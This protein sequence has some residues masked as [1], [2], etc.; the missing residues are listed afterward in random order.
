MKSQTSD[1]M[2]EGR[3]A[4]RNLH[5]QIQSGEVQ[6]QRNDA[7]EIIETIQIFGH[8][9]GA[10]YAAGMAEELQRLNYK[11]ENVYYL[12]PHQPGGIIHPKGIRGQQYSHPKDQV[13]S[14]APSWLP[15]GKSSL[16]PIQGIG[17]G[18]REYQ[19]PSWT[20]GLIGKGDAG[21]HWVS[22]HGYIFNN[23]CEG[24]PGYVAPSSS[25]G[26]AVENPNQGE[27]IKLS[28]ESTW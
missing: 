7:G 16:A 26:S 20:K 23:T 3:I 19:D 15:N 8:S 9:H 28:G 18:Y 21:G 17:D 25:P 13:S 27:E 5:T 22:L 10:A 14:D 6:L 12:A 2:E 1:R 11:V 4:A 24:S